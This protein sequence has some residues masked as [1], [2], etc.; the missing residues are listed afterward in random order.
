MSQCSFILCLFPGVFK[1]AGLICK[2]TG[3]ISNLFQICDSNFEQYLIARF[4]S[5]FC[6]FHS[7]LIWNCALFQSIFRGLK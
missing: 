3:E 7:F 2:D 5:P 4:V 6:S 1:I